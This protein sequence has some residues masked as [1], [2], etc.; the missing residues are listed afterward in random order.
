MMLTAHGGAVLVGA[1]SPSVLCK[2]VTVRILISNFYNKFSLVF[3]YALDLECDLRN[4][5][6]NFFFNDLLL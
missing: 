4:S 5:S 3:I 2:L 6:F 1:F